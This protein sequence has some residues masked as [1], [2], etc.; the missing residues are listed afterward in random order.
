MTGSLD[1]FFFDQPSIP[2]H[3]DLSRVFESKEH[4]WFYELTPLALMLVVR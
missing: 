4:I 2:L 3:H 1:S